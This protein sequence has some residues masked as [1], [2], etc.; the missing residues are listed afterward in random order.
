[1]HSASGEPD[2][3]DKQNRP[4]KRELE[5]GGRDG[6]RTGKLLKGAGSPVLRTAASSAW[7]VEIG[8]ES[9]RPAEVGF[10]P[11]GHTPPHMVDSPCT[12]STN[13][14]CNGP[15]SKYFHIMKSLDIFPTIKKCKNHS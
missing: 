4:N 13:F 7:P 9:I 12:G 2:G 5:A 6:G 15:E 8:N 10:L 11:E 1:M 14:F 3:T